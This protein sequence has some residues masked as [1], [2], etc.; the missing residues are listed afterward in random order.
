MPWRLIGGAFAFVRSPRPAGVA[1]LER[2]CL[3]TRA[4]GHIVRRALCVSMQCGGKEASTYNYMEVE[5][6]SVATH[7]ATQHFSI[8]ILL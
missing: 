7:S 1:K 5:F 3:V 4:F 2:E 8:A 6:T